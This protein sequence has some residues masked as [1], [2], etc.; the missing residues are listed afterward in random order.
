MKRAA[1]GCA[2]RHSAKKKPFKE[3][4]PMKKIAYLGVDYHLNHLSIAVKVSGKKKFYDVIRL[5]NKDKTVKKYL[6]KLSNDFEIKACYEA[7]SSGYVFQRKMASWGYHCDVIAPSLIP[8]KRGERRKNDFRDA[9]ELARLYAYGLLTV[10]HPPNEEEESV[11]SLIRCRLAFKASEKKVKQQINA[12]LLSHDYRWLK[13]KWTNQHRKWLSELELPYQY[14]QQVLDE[15]VEHLRYLQSRIQYL[16]GQ[17]EKLAQSDI[18]VESVKKL[19]A[20]KG[21]DTL[22][23]MLLIAEIT[24]FRRFPNPRALMAFLGLIPSEDSSGD[25]QKGGGITRSGNH[26]CRKMLVESVQHYAKIPRISLKM[27]ANLAQIDAQSAYIATKCLSRLHK[28][29]WALTMKGK[30]RPVVITAIAREFVGFIWAMMRPE[31]S[32]TYCVKEQ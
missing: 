8:K 24:D 30:I 27:R 11:R 26:R 2:I 18:Y 5:E 22:T 16:D 1:P 3:E 4:Q 20:F 31:T 23:A 7:S 15:Y 19:K 9:R 12:L 21:I 14:L 6:K 32:M 17:I 25:K 28:R 29:Y 10:V 13:S